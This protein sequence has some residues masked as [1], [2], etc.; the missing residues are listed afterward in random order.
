MSTNLKFWRQMPRVCECP[1]LQTKQKLQALVIVI[2]SSVAMIHCRDEGG[3]SELEI[4]VQEI[5]NQE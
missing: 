1:D 5:R 3:G 2:T 4:S